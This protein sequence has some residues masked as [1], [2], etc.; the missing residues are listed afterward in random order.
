MTFLIV[1]LG[2]PGKQHRR[3]R[4]NVGSTCVDT[5]YSRYDFPQGFKP[6]KSKFKADVAVCDTEKFL[7][8]PTILCKSKRYMNESGASVASIA[9]FYQVKHT[10]VIVFHDDVDL[11]VGEVRY[12]FGGSSGGHNGLKSIN[13]YIGKNYHR[14]RIGVGRPTEEFGGSKRCDVS[15]YVLRTLS[16]EEE[17]T[18]VQAME[19]VL[20]IVSLLLSGKDE[21]FNKQ[22]KRIK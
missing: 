14:I 5:L 13:D 6:I 17:A 7:G 12:K 21:E 11:P 16:D 2:N 18:I 19:K 8:S 4:H 9:S 20:D 15:D 10:N 1:G 3:T 22:I